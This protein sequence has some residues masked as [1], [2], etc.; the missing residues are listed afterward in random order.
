MILAIAHYVDL[1]I[2]VASY[3]E[4]F[5]K[6]RSRKGPFF[7]TVDDLLLGFLDLEI[8]NVHVKT[9]SSCNLIVG[10]Y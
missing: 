6:P 5:V 3:A 7:V 9:L 10:A 8:L 4:N 2:Y 1:Q